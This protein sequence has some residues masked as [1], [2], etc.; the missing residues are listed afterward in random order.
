METFKLIQKKICGNK[1]LL[2]ISQVM[3]KQSFHLT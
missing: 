3:E 2:K 1:I